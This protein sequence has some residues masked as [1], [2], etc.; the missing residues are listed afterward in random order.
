LPESTL[1][2][3][4][5]SPTDLSPKRN[6]RRRKWHLLIVKKTA[7]LRSTRCGRVP[8]A[9]CW[10]RTRELQLSPSGWLLFFLPQGTQSIKINVEENLFLLDN[11]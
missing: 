11:R 5:Q 1:I 7:D 2:P 10:G 8:T 6:L 3:K 9:R 4:E